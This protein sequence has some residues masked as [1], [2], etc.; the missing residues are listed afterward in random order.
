MGVAAD[1]GGMVNT[2]HGL[3]IGM[4]GIVVL[5]G[6]TLVISSFVLGLG[7][8]ASGSA[9]VGASVGGAQDAN[10]FR[11]NVENGYVPQ[12]TDVTYEGLYHDYYFDVNRSAPC[13]RRFCPTY[14]RAVSPD[15][16]SNETDRYLAVGLTSGIEQS[17]FERPNVT[18]VVVVDT[19]G[20][21]SSQ[22]SQ[23][24]YD[25]GDGNAEDGLTKMEAARR[26][27]GALYDQLGPDD[28]L[29][30]VTYD[31]SARVV[32]PVRRT[33]EIDD[34]GFESRVDGMTADG[35]TDLSAGM[36]T[37]RGM[38]EPYKNPG[39]NRTTRVVYLT[40]AMPNRG[41]LSTDRLESDLAADAERGVYST[42]VGVG[43]DFNSAFTDSLGSVRG[44][45]YYTVDSPS[46]FE[47]RM[48]DGFQYMVTPL[49]F[50]LELSVAAPDYRVVAAYGTPSESERL[51]DVSTLFPSRTTENGSEG[52]VILL[53]LERT[54]EDPGPVTVRTNYTD[55]DGERHTSAATVR[56]PGSGPHYDT[57]GVRKA[58]VLTRYGTLMRN[59][60]AHERARDG[61]DEFDPP[62][63]VDHRELR[64]WEQ[65]SVPLSVSAPYD[66]RLK[67]FRAYFAAEMEALEAGRMDRDLTVLRELS[68]AD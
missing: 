29:G 62:D 47:E 50:D 3:A 23:Y 8:E 2:K 31:S 21:M 58:I 52:S 60:A 59:W 55:P 9:P 16:L 53:E 33:G 64:G 57:T 22:F 56:M 10:N 14:A 6:A 66:D 18:L 26:S 19:S 39:E 61:G 40:D 45:N 11:E 15:P 7:N 34:V 42:F 54:G 41:E 13:N 36:E 44:A 35:S 12:P 17:E 67:Q 30:V 4:V 28:R 63:G 65:R 37:A 25:G 48:G 51:L 20:S 49:A 68:A 24:H 27:V 32:Q 38:V 46:A 43:V 1:R 5:A